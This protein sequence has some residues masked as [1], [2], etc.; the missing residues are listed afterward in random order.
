[1]DHRT[2]SFARRFRTAKSRLGSKDIQGLVSL[3]YRHHYVNGPEY[4][5]F[6]DDHLRQ[7][8]GFDVTRVDGDFGGQA[9]LVTDKAQNKAILVEHETG[10][11]ILGAIGSV[12]SLIAL[13]PLISSGWTNLRHR[14]FRPH[15]DHPD[16][17]GIEVRR[18]DQNEV[19]IEQR[20]PSIEVYVLNATLQD[21][22]LMKQKVD[23]LEAQIENLQKRLPANNRKGTVQRR[24]KAT[25]K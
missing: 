1:M 8:L 13:L 15:L 2:E 16:G 3:K 9:W 7:T 19:L 5:Q 4:S 24:K 20:V 12:A 11:E 22:A 21:Y 25:K 23:Q 6:I 10:L 17:E 18:L 14:F